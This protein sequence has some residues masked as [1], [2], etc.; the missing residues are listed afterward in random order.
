MSRLFRV[1][2]TQPVGVIFAIC[3]CL[4][5]LGL[6][7]EALTAFAPGN[8]TAFLITIGVYLIV[9]LVTIECEKRAYMP[10][11]SYLSIMGKGV[12]IVGF[13]LCLDWALAYTWYQA[14]IFLLVVV[15]LPALLYPRRFPWV[16]GA[17]PFNPNSSPTDLPH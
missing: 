13:A 4:V 10:N 6:T 16:K 3:F 9:G 7:R 1:P 2:R 14:L 8:R 12:Y 15:F 5:L 11:N 17:S